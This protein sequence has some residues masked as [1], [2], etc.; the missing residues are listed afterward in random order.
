MAETSSGDEGAFYRIRVEGRLGARR[1]ERLAGMTLTVQEAA[2]GTA[3]ATELTG[4][5]VD[6]AA[7]MGVLEQLYALGAKVLSVRR[8][9][10]GENSGR[11]GPRPPGG[12]EED[13]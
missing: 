7:L 8:L 6:E 12:K 9:K 3:P 1:A 4:R 5:L 2:A 13:R 11:Q 10:T